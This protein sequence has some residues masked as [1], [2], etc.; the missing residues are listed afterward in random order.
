MKHILNSVKD[1]LVYTAFVVRGGWSNPGSQ[2]RREARRKLIRQFPRWYRNRLRSGGPQIHALPWITYDAIDFLDALLTRSMTVFE[3]GSGGSTLWLSM[4]V[5]Q[6]YSVEH[7]KTWGQRVRRELAERSIGN[8]HLQCVLPVPLPDGEDGPDPMDPM[9]YGTM[10]K[11]LARYQFKAYVASIDVHPAGHFDVILLDGRCRP[12][13]VWHAIPKL[14]AGGYLILDNSDRDNYARGI[15]LL[16]GWPRWDFAGFAPWVGAL[17]T[18]TS[19]YR[20]PNGPAGRCVIP[21]QGQHREEAHPLAVRPRPS[22]LCGD[23]GHETGT[24]RPARAAI[25]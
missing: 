4:R 3:Y 6:L 8:C 18:K 24:P 21:T 13:G 9:Q 12:A 10:D 19:F 23:P 17:I 16:D 2:S 1:L 20:K 11:A 25:Q 14:R 7:E 5:G 22:L 15:A